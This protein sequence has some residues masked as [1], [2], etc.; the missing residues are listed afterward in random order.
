MAVVDEFAVMFG[1]NRA[2]E[3]AVLV[4]F[5]VVLN[6]QSDCFFVRHVWCLSVYGDVFFLL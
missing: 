3:F 1:Q 4:I 6:V 2:H 5:F